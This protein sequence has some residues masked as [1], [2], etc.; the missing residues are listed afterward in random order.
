[1]ANIRVD[2]GSP[3]YAGQTITFKSPA[4][5]SAVTGLKVYYPDGNTTTS[6]TFQFADAHGNNVGGS[7]LFASNV[8]VKVILDTE[9]N[10]AYVQNADTNAYLEGKFNTKLNG[11]GGPIKKYEDMNDYT[12]DGT[13]I[14]DTSVAQTLSNAPFTS[15][16]C[17][18]VRKYNSSGSMIEQEAW[19]ASTGKAIR[20]HRMKFGGS[21]WGAWIG[22]SKIVTGWYTGTGTYGPQGKNTLTFKSSPIIILIMKYDGSGFM[23]M[24]TNTNFVTGHFPPNN[25]Y[26]TVEVSKSYSEGDCTIQWYNSTTPWYQFNEAHGSYRY[27]AFFED[28]V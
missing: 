11:Y 2:V 17:L 6:K 16:F 25:A 26:P 22:E 10:R 21:G 19:L 7:D 4:D 5:C 18:K 8:L 24:Y 13:F 14:C 12:S 15:A 27:I 1:M 23:F 9:L 3:V 28:E 20:M